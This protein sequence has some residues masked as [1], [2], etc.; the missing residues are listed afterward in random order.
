MLLASLFWTYPTPVQAKTKTLPEA[1]VEIKQEVKEPYGPR[2]NLLRNA[3]QPISKNTKTV[4]KPKTPSI[5]S[6]VSPTTPSN[7]PSYSGRHYSKEEVQALIIRYSQ[8]YNIN[9]SVPLCIAKYES[10]YNQFSKNKSSSAA[11]VFQYLSRTW[12]G[13]DEGKAGLSVYDAGANVKAAIK[14][15]ASRKSAKPWAVAHKCPSL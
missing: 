13:T 11:G 9:A 4:L 7:P 1:K 3:V 15:M 10:G 2:S 8:Q 6:K 12:A 14:Y 5:T